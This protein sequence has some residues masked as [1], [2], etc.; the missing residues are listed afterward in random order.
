M[1]ENRVQHVLDGNYEPLSAI[2]IFVKDLGL[3][4]ETGKTQRFPLP[5]AAAAHQ[6]FLAANAAGY[7]QED[8]DAVI[9][10][11]RDLAGL[12]LPSKEG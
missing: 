4:L 10:V 11:Y 8:D 7:G 9:K 5:V 12:Q 2:D 6:Q 3:V 1:F